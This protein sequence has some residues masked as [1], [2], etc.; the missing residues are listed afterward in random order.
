LRGLLDQAR[1]RRVVT[2]DEKK[3]RSWQQQFDQ[4]RLS[5]ENAVRKARGEEPIKEMAD[6][7]TLEEQ[8]ALDPESTDE[9]MSKDPYLKE[10]GQILADLVSLM[11]HQRVADKGA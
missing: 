6:L 10:T 8:R 2:L 7:R 9:P 4:Q 11:S 1:E 3:R 5:I